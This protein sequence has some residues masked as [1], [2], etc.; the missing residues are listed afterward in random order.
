MT[1]PP[2]L[3]L[4]RE[5]YEKKGLSLAS[6]GKRVGVHHE[7]VRMAFKRAGIPTRSVKEAQWLWFRRAKKLTKGTKNKRYVIK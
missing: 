1:Y 6:V 4:A 3:P 5:L 7:T 2:W